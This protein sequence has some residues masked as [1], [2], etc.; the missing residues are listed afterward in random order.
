MKLSQELSQDLTRDLTRDFLGGEGNFQRIT[1]TVS[2]NALSQIKS[3]LRTSKNHYKPYVL[4]FAHLR[5]KSNGGAPRPT[6]SDLYEKA[7]ELLKDKIHYN[8]S[9]KYIYKEP[10]DLEWCINQED[11]LK[12]SLCTSQACNRGHFDGDRR[13]GRKMDTNYINLP[14]DTGYTKALK[15][16]YT[17]CFKKAVEAI[18]MEGGRLS[19]TK[20]N[21]RK[22]LKNR[23]RD[24]HRAFQTP[25]SRPSKKQSKNG[26]RRSLR[27]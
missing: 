11:P 20:K 21:A 16:R 23:H 18:E 19:K 27:R 8:L 13:F 6:K 3:E 25:R 26:K 5:K 9:N 7:Y 15:H 17:E 10:Q 2:P 1:E 24:R 14:D 4:P 12:Q 22:P